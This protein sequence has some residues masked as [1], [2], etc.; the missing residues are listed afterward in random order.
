[1]DA[2]ASASPA[3]SP[4]STPYSPPEN[5][6]SVP[7]PT[8]PTAS[9]M[10]PSLSLPVPLHQ[11]RFEPDSPSQQY[12]TFPTSRVSRDSIAAHHGSRSRSS[13]YSRSYH[14]RSPAT[15]TYSYR[16]RPG[17]Q[18]L[19]PV[20]EESEADRARGSRSAGSSPTS[21]YGPAIGMGSYAEAGPDDTFMEDITLAMLTMLPSQHQRSVKR[22]K[23]MQRA[24]SKST[25]KRAAGATGRAIS[26]LCRV[27]RCPPSW[28][29]TRRP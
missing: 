18:Q 11:T 17:T 20:A 9:T 21:R 24:Q 3:A 26:A 1:M 25:V 22:R 6:N 5:S 15:S 4:L 7:F 23:A 29:T 12:Y 28:V 8:V 2:S 14:V 13:S 27:I 16:A 10:Q 19:S